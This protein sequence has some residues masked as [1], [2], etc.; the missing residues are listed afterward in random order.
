M[1]NTRFSFFPMQ[2]STFASQVD[3]LTITLLILCCI[4]CLIVFGLILFFGIRYRNGSPHSRKIEKQNQQTVEWSWT[5]GTLVLFL[6]LFTWS[7]VIY[8]QMHAPPSDSS[9]I[10][11]V[12][13]QWMWKFQHSTGKREINELHVPVGKPIL[14]TMTSQDVVHSFFVP[15]FR[16][17]QDVLPG[18]Y[19]RTWFE[20]TKTG[21]YH[22]FCS[23]YCG[24]MH[25]DMRGKVIVQSQSDYQNWLQSN[26]PIKIP[27][28]Y[29]RL[30]CANCHDRTSA[31]RAPS[32]IGIF[33]KRE[34][35]SDGSTILVDENYLRESIL[36]PQAKIVKGY[37]P[38][39]PSYA[40][41]LNEEDILDLIAFIK[42]QK[43]TQ[44]NDPRNSQ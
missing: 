21:E 4:I 19:S 43:A 7:T 9:E 37:P 28:L 2:A 35:L 17:K 31:I 40:G 22:L 39:M 25:S 13:K 38:V 41:Q 23:Q 20:A 16:I 8:F 14:L 36:N 18:R 32:L 11:V 3:W 24:T 6:A 29:N 34:T 5:V 10:W 33:G 42:A 44:E 1:N 30:G 12:G 15:A 27:T 26:P